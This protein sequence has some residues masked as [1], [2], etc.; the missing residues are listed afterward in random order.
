MV[1]SVH[2]ARIL[3]LQKTMRAQNL[4]AIIA[5]KPQTFFYLSDFNPI[6][7]SHPT[8]VVLPADGQPTLIVWSIRFDHAHA[9]SMIGDI[10]LFGRWGDRPY[11]SEDPNDALVQVIFE[12]GLHRGLL[13]IEEDHV[14]AKLL[15]L[16]SEIMPEATF[17]DASSLINQARLVKDK[18]EI[19]RLRRATKIA[20]AGM[21]AATEAI[22]ERR[23]EAEIAAQAEIAMRTLWCREYPDH[24]TAGFAGSEGGIWSSLWCWVHSGPRL[25]LESDTPKSRQVREG[26]LVLPQ[27]W[28]TCDG[29]TAENGRTFAIG[30]MS[31]DVRRAFDVVIAAREAA[32]SA[33][34][35]GVRC[36]NVYEAAAM[37]MRNAGY[38]RILP[39]RI[40]HS[41]GL[42]PHEPLSLA[43]REDMLL[44]EGIVLAVEPGLSFPGATVRH[45]DTIVVTRGGNE[46]LTTTPRGVLIV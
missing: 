35:P 7:F 17:L 24:E 1:K 4:D 41:I 31:E 44:E 16:W 3:R 11:L 38:E 40:G 28:A 23:T 25:A 34:R 14:S 33:I 30:S 32:F 22:V 10:R 37:V 5:T 18:E 9:E 39:G 6:I 20:D 29:Y 36:S 45:S 8:M 13:G 27:I 21:L 46:I 15:R 42:G 43:A 19:T 2:D 26:D 12:R